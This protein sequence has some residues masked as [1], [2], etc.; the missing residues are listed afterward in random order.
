MW[1]QI[2][3]YQP[4]TTEVHESTVTNR[5]EYSYLH[6]QYRVS[7]IEPTESRGNIHYSI[8]THAAL[9]E[10]FATCW[11]WLLCVLLTERTNDT[12]R[13]AL[14][15]AHR[16]TKR[17]KKFNATTSTET[18]L[19]THAYKHAASHFCTLLHRYIH[20]KLYHHSHSIE[21]TTKLGV[22]RNYPILRSLAHFLRFL[23]VFLFS[24]QSAVVH[25]EHYVLRMLCPAQQVCFHAIFDWVSTIIVPLLYFIYN[26]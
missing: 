3:N 2:I 25:V 19:F 22:W 16:S 9:L 12:R 8:Q 24:L 14:T 13:A 20:F 5:N 21:R 1:R 7:N 23:F 4:H 17:V 11:Q 6:T 10:L 18:C 26:L 15:V